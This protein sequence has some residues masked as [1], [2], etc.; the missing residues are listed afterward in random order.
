MPPNKGRWRLSTLNKW[1]KP[2]ATLNP[3][4]RQIFRHLQM[5]LCEQLRLWV[6]QVIHTAH[7]SVMGPTG[8]HGESQNSTLQ[9]FISGSQ[10]F[11]GPKT[12]SE[13]LEL[14]LWEKSVQYD[15][16][17]QNSDTLCP[18]DTYGINILKIPC[19]E[20][21]SQTPLWKQLDYTLQ[22]SKYKK[23]KKVQTYLS[24]SGPPHKRL[25]DQYRLPFVFPVSLWEFVS[26]AARSSA[27]TGPTRNK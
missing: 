19:L 23:K 18:R 25:R 5:T 3:L 14:F 13:F 24:S 27:D 2:T 22:Y 21:L 17:D 7:D 15:Y 4:K 10:S 26:A 20:T 9:Q 12:P 11:I 16:H 1:R 6:L 8:K